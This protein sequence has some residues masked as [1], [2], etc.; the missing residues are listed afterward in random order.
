MFGDEPGQGKRGLARGVR[1][2]CLSLFSS[3]RDEKETSS[4]DCGTGLARMSQSSKIK[5]ML[6]HILDVR[7]HSRATTRV[8]S[9][10]SCRR[11]W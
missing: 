2:E 8:F 1:D 7:R 6:A 3:P 4:R 9:Q 5:W 11:V 10:R